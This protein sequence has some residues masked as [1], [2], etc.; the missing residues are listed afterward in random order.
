[1]YCRREMLRVDAARWFVVG[2]A[3]NEVAVAV[4]VAAAMA[5]RL[6]ALSNRTAEVLRIAVTGG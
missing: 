6:P 2:L 3:A 5:K 1:M 4:A